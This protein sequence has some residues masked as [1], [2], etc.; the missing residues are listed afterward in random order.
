MLVDCRQMEVW[1]TK[2]IGG[3]GVFADPTVGVG[4]CHVRQICCLRGLAPLESSARRAEP[5]HRWLGREGDGS[6]KAKTARGFSCM[7]L[8]VTETRF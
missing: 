6:E 3:G 8:P 2:S 7:H 1:I 4:S 5:R